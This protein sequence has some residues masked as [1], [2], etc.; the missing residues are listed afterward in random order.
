MVSVSGSSCP[1]RALA[2]DNA[3]ASA[4]QLTLSVSLYAA[5]QM[6]TG[7]FNVAGNQAKLR[8]DRPLGSYRLYL[9]N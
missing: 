6:G 7:D 2:S 1:Y 3:F 8:P 4:T 9:S 5:E